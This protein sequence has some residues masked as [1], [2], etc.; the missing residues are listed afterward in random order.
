VGRTGLEPAT[1][2]PFTAFKDFAS[3]STSSRCPN[4]FTSARGV[5]SAVKNKNVACTSNESSRDGKWW[6]S[7]PLSQIDGLGCATAH[8]GSEYLP[9]LC[10]YAMETSHINLTIYDG[11][12]SG[13]IQQPLAHQLTTCLHTRIRTLAFA[14]CGCR[15]QLINVLS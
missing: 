11:L 13:A 8:S 10:Q 5:D 9:L 2:C 4:H 1:F 14:V 7:D 3:L 12:N 6:E 15:K